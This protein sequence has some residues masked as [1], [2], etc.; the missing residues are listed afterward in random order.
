MNALG[1]DSL[2]T[3]WVRATEFRSEGRAGSG[4]EAHTIE[5]PEI[6]FVMNGFSGYSGIEN[7]VARCYLL[8]GGYATAALSEPSLSQ[9]DNRF[10]RESDLRHH[11][12]HSGLI[13]EESE[14]V[15]II[16]VKN[17]TCFSDPARG[18]RMNHEIEPGESVSM[19]VIDAI[20]STA[21]RD[22]ASMRPLAEML[23]PDALDAL[24]APRENGE[25]RPGGEVSFIYS[26]YRVTIQNGEFISIRQMDS[27]ESRTR[28]VGDD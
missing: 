20:S 8:S 9:R 3:S 4:F 14:T 26:G 2:G 19:A 25:Q 18:Y 13:S 10:A 12:G 28:I 24:F 23:D 6:T 17:S 1:T 11:T 22:P 16:W 15:V 27:V 21:N 7:A 5:K